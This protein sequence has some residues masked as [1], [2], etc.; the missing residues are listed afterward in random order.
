M[1]RVLSYEAMQE[2]ARAQKT[3]GLIRLTTVFDIALD[4]VSDIPYVT[5]ETPLIARK[6]RRGQ[7]AIRATGGAPKPAP[8]EER[9]LI[10]FGTYSDGLIAS[11][12]V[13][14]CVTDEAS[15]ETLELQGGISELSVPYHTAVEPSLDAFSLKDGMSVDEFNTVM[16]N[17]S[18]AIERMYRTL[19]AITI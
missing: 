5:A 16:G 10:A 6:T 19:A 17:R 7:F 13:R 9:F 11:L 4:N 15:K 18:A 12:V 2:H 14:S 8:G 1:N 3:D